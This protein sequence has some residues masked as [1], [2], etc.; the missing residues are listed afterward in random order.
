MEALEEVSDLQAIFKY[1]FPGK[2]LKRDCWDFI[3]NYD[4]EYC[5]SV[6]FYPP[7]GCLHH[8]VIHP[9]WKEG[10]VR[11]MVRWYKDERTAKNAAFM[12]FLQACVDGGILKDLRHLNNGRE[13]F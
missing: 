12:R 9:T 4:Y 2:L 7:K 3:F 6:R 5:V 11:E 1:I 13:L 10:V 8:S